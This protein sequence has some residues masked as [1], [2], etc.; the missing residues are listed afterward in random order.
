MQPSFYIT[1]DPPSVGTVGRDG[2][3]SE[4]NGRN[5]DLNAVPRQC[6]PSVVSPLGR[7]LAARLGV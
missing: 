6:P 5:L 2:S 3:H 7:P 4:N 1:W